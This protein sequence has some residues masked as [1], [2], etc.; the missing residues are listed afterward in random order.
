MSAVVPL[1]KRGR[2]VA[3]W[4]LDGGITRRNGENYVYKDRQVSRKSMRTHDNGENMQNFA[5]LIQQVYAQQEVLTEIKICPSPRC[6]TRQVVWYTGLLIMNVLDHN[7]S[8][9]L[10]LII[11]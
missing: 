1:K 2:R 7:C 3:H 4:Q 5:Q 11:Y 10:Y 8:Y 6:R 9:F